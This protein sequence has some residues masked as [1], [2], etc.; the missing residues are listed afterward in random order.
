[1]LLGV[2]AVLM[3]WRQVRYFIVPVGLLIFTVPVWD[4]LSW[5]LQVIT[6]EI[7]RLL[8]GLMDIEFR[9]EGVF[10]YL[11]GVGTFEVA[12]GCSGLRYLLVGQSLAVIY[13]EL[14]LQR[15]RSR[16][17][18]FLAGVLLALVANWIRVF[19]II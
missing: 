9:V 7:N 16:V 6:V 4:F 14:N 12:H 17:I 1:I 3:G 18:I 11:I 13:G 8:L 5:N 2:L 10:V 19:V 15:V